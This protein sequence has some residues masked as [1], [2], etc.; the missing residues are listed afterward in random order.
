MVDLNPNGCRG[1][2]KLVVLLSCSL[3][4]EVSMLSSTTLPLKGKWGKETRDDRTVS[5]SLL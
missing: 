5:K 4:W 3:Y 2:S 1:D